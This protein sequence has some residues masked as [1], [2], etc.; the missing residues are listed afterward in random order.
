MNPSKKEARMKKLLFLLLVLGWRGPAGA[1]AV[2]DWNETTAGATFAA[3]LSTLD[4][5]HESRIFAM[6][7]A[8]IHDA[9]NAIERRFQPYAFDAQAAAGT[10]PEAAVAAAAHDVLIELFPQIPDPPFPPAAAAAATVLAEA[11]YIAALAAI[12]DGPAKTQ[13]VQIGQDAAAAILALRA[14]DG[15]DSTFL[16]ATYQP[17]PNPGDF[18]FIPGT[19]FALAPGWGEVTPFVLTSSSQYRPKAPYALSSKNYAADF[20]EVKRLGA[21]NST[22]RTAEQTEI[23]L[24]WE[25]SSPQGWNRI[26]RIASAQHGLELWENARLFGLLNFA[27]ADGYI[28]DFENKYFYKFW[29]PITAIRAANT[30]GNPDTVEDPNWDSLHPTPPAPDYTSGHSVE[31]GAMSEVLARVFGTD[32]ISFSM[33]ST[34]LPG[35][36]RSFTSFSQA[37]EENGNSRVYIG[38][39]FRHAVTEGIKL[40]RKVGKVV[41]NHFLKPVH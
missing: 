9:L 18:Q 35:V 25:E 36:T 1:D 38:F 20:N 24:F 26:A 14:A 21:I 13:G 40:G 2:I 39:H 41:F 6:M 16:D 5:L 30:D 7:H 8:A 31:G 17:G 4:P 29:R 10:S 34:T 28:A 27:S 32:K 3:G 23:A 19:D 15:S 12:P 22:A 33:T 11:A 37:A